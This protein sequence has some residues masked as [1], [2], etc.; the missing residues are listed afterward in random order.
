MARLSDDEIEERRSALEGW[1]RDGDAIH[2]TFEL[3]D[4][5][6]GRMG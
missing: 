6:N 5:K 2:R 1:K 3:E 4:F